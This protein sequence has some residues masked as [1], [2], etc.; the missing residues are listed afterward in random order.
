MKKVTL[1][2]AAIIMLVVSACNSSQKKDNQSNKK[3]N[4]ET[5]AAKTSKKPKNVFVKDEILKD[6]KL[7]AT[8][9]KYSQDDWNRI[10]KLAKAYNTFEKENKGKPETREMLE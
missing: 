3:D 6:L 2:S 1:I 9:D 10:S 4:S 5:K 7:T 8:S